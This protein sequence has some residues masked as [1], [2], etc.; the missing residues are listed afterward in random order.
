LFCFVFVSIAQPC[1]T[2]NSLSDSVQHSLALFRLQRLTGLLD[3]N[4]SR[5]I[6]DKPARVKRQRHLEYAA[7]RGATPSLA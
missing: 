3:T 6:T 5:K 1:V 4:K 2:G 7:A